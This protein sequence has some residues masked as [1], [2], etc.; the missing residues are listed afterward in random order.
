MYCINLTMYYHFIGVVNFNAR[1]SCQKCT[2]IGEYSREFKRMSF[3][4]LN[5]ERRNNDSFRQRK[6]SEHHKEKSPFENL[7]ID[8]VSAFST[9]DSL[10]LLDL[11][12]MKRC[13]VRWI[14]GEKGYTRKWPKN[15]VANVSKLL[16]NCQKYMPIDMH[17]AV[18]N[19]NCVKKWKGLEYR[20]MLVYIG[21]V[22]LKGALNNDE[23]NHFLTICCAVRICMCDSFK[24]FWSIAEQMFQSYV[25]RYGTLYG[26]HSIGSNVHLLIHIIED[27]EVQKVNSLM[28]LS[29]YAYENALRLL[30]MKVRHGYLP[31]EQVSRRI[32]EMTQLRQKNDS[33]N[34]LKVEQFV[35]QLQYPNEITLHQTVM[36]YQTIKITPNLILTS[37]KSN[38]SWFFTKNQQIV[39]MQCA[40]FENGKHFIIGL[41]IV[42]KSYLFS[43]NT[44][45]PIDSTKLQIFSS[46]GALDHAP[47][48]FELN[49]F[50]CKMIYLPFEDNFAFIP[51]I[52]TMNS[53]V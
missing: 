3:P 22:T 19:L 44:G 32:I 2:T 10:H 49:D 27:M 23:Y 38:D 5:A 17:R 6:H 46:D 45:A 13:M 42:N 8:M 1:H 41:I 36:T 39:K 15:I 16:E 12:I 25:Q 40:I 52:H 30:G 4:N 26:I 24:K 34:S 11:G 29:T 9:S 43:R 50:A 48:T 35:P 7:K 33:S 28:Q 51:I 21:M 47:R 31:L 53:I 37:R 20:N 18:R 14:F